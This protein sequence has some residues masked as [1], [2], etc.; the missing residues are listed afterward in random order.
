MLY[1]L[2][3]NLIVNGNFPDTNKGIIELD[4]TFMLNNV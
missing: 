2:Y 3:D 1:T 4:E